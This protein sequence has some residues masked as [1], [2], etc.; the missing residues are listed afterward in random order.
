M[1]AG[2]LVPAAKV[3]AASYMYIAAVMLAH[4]N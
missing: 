2:L 4:N 1:V 3:H